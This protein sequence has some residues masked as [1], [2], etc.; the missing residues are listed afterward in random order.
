MASPLVRG[1]IMS[2][3]VRASNAVGWSNFSEPASARI[4][5]RPSGGTRIADLREEGDALRV[6][7]HP[8]LDAG[9]GRPASP[10]DGVTITA[11]TLLLSR[12]AL[13][14]PLCSEKRVVVDPPSPVGASNISFLLPAAGYLVEGIVYY[15]R[16]TASNAVGASYESQAEPYRFAYRQTQTPEP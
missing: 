2:A 8:P 3:A 16:V 1:S 14:G 11:Y 9:F 4:M 15:L 5:G 12:C 7:W 13:P 6:T 10:E